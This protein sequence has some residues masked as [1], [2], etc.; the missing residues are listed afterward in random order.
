MKEKESKQ[1]TNKKEETPNQGLQQ[2][3]LRPHQIQPIGILEQSK[4]KVSS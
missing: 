3:R 2:T 1:I 4:K